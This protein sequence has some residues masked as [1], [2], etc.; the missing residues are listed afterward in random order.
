MAAGQLW[1]N[2]VVYLFMTKFRPDFK[3]GVLGQQVIQ[4]NTG[5]QDM[6]GVN[7]ETVTGS[8]KEVEGQQGGSVPGTVEHN[9][10][11]YDM[12]LRV[13]SGKYVW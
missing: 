3:A 13:T 1:Q 2:V 5:Q 6:A 7:S 12:W 9:T 8:C 10:Q 4:V 11:E